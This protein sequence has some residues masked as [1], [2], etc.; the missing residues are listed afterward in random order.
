MTAVIIGL[1]LFESVDVSNT[2]DSTIQQIMEGRWED[3][4]T[5]A[6]FVLTHQ[7]EDDLLLGLLKL[8]KLKRFISELN[9][10]FIFLVDNRESE[11]LKAW[12]TL[13]KKNPTNT[14]ILYALATLWIERDTEKAHFYANKLLESDSSST[15][16]YFIMGYT[17]E[18]NGEYDEAIRNYHR[19]WHLDTT[20]TDCIGVLANVYL[21]KGDYD[22]AL[23][24]YQKI[25]YDDTMYR[26]MHI[27]EI[28]CELKRRNI[29][30]ADSIL[31][32]L[33]GFENDARTENSL[34]KMSEY[35]SGMRTNSLTAHDTIVIF[36]PLIVKHMYLP[37]WPTKLVAVLTKSDLD[38]LNVL[39]QETMVAQT[40]TLIDQEI[41]VVQYLE[42]APT[43]THIPKPQYPESARKANIE[44]NVVVKVLVDIDGRV[45]DTEVLHSSG[46]KELDNAAME[47]AARAIFEPA[48]QFGRPVRI[49]VSIPIKFV[50][51]P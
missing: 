16:A 29:W 45:I 39:S 47:A 2:R 19:S 48:M 9:P 3:A 28:I 12:E 22:N 32:I 11:I 36:I 7:P 15:F 51:T 43:P 24:Y 50:L 37:R 1:L 42:T 35:M 18:H 49:W 27:G 34:A 25:P 20:S 44:G 30:G 13:H 46:Y 14:N 33:E 4:I 10:K 41:E 26:V 17:H 21:M 31:R 6:K 40:R 23:A 8:G 38:V 5:N